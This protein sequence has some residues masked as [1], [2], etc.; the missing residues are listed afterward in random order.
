MLVNVY[1][2]TVSRVTLGLRKWCL[3]VSRLF[4]TF[5]WPF[6]D[7]FQESL[8]LADALYKADIGK[9]PKGVLSM[10]VWL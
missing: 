4:N 1:G 8:F 10:Q 6:K 7:K 2:K 9:D 3:T 5:K